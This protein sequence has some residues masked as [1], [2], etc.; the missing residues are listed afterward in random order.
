P[1]RQGDM[2]RANDD[3]AAVRGPAVV[4]HLPEDG[5]ADREALPARR[6]PHVRVAPSLP[7]RLPMP[8][9]PLTTE[10]CGAPSNCGRGSALI[11][12]TATTSPSRGGCAGEP[13]TA[14]SRKSPPLKRS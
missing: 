4:V 9:K 12:V 8:A 5:T 3:A 14:S 2:A 10:P 7:A 6:R 13:M 11:V 1:S